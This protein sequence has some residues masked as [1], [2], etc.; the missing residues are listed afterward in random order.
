MRKNVEIKNVKGTIDYLPKEESVR[1]KVRRTLEDIFMAYGCLPI[2]TPIINE[3]QLLASKYGGGAEILE[4][5]YLLTDRGKRELA[6]RYDLTIPF[7]KV[8]AM[9]PTLSMPFKRYEIGKVFRDGP[10]KTG[11]YREFTQCDVDIVGVQSQLAEAELI[12]MA[13]D[14]FEKLGIDIEIEIN[15]RKL[16][17]GVLKSFEVDP[18]KINSAILTIDKFLKIGV[19][20]V[21]KELKGKAVEAESIKKIIEFLNKK[22]TFEEFKKMD[23]RN[24]S[25]LEGVQETEELLNYLDAIDLTEC[26]VF[27]PYLAR[28]LEIYTGTIYEIF[29]KDSSIQ[30]SIGA[31][32]RYDEAVGGFLGTDDCYPTVGLSFG[33]DVICNALGQRG[34]N[35]KSEIDYYIIPLGYEQEAL[36][37]AKNLRKNGFYVEMELGTKKITKALKKANRI[38]VQKVILIGE[39]EVKEGFYTEKEMENGEEKQIN[40]EYK[41]CGT[42]Q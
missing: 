18:E 25:F 27:N 23:V 2:E 37:V 5:M 42:M 8:I 33:L 20:G 39:K 34:Q 16:L 7:V 29:L 36:Q 30:S 35:S 4:E 13:V 28:G 12:S 22:W 14:A 9:N 38:A 15:N 1:R 6:L 10:I 19:D 41:V 21:V 17:S 31:G 11:R 24:E 26:C 40:F 3:V 32:G